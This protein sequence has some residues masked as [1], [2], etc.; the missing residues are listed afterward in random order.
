ME[1]MQEDQDGFADR[2]NDLRQTIEGFSVY[3]DLGKID[4]YYENVEFVNLKLKEADGESKLFNA[5]E[6]LFGAD[7]TD[8][9]YAGLKIRNTNIIKY[10]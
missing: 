4:E 10:H 1:E 2:M 5:R 7:N 6:T 8:Y 9:G 3:S